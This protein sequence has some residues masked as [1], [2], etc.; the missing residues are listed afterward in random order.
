MN[1]LHDTYEEFMFDV[2][3][4]FSRH[5]WVDTVGIAQINVTYRKRYVES[6]F[7]LCKKKW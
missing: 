7:L 4:L 1:V 2:L 3:I 5:N 6:I